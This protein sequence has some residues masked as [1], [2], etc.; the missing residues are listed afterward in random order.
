MFLIHAEKYKGY[1]PIQQLIHML[2]LRAGI[3]P[4]VWFYSHHHKTVK[5]K[6]YETGKQVSFWKLLDIRLFLKV[7]AK[8]THR[9]TTSWIHSLSLWIPIWLT[10]LRLRQSNWLNIV[11]NT[12]TQTRNSNPI[13]TQITS[14]S[15]AW[16]G[17]L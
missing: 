7:T 1:M 8:I 17:T 15:T 6:G 10:F 11:L 5:K 14:S 13:Q 9:A 3:K 16:F 4:A 2:K 12:H